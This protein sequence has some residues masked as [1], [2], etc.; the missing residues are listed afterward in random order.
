R[1]DISQDQ[2]QD[3]ER[4]LRLVRPKPLGLLSEQPALELAA[5]LQHL[6]VEPVVL[7]AVALSLL[8][9]L[10]RARLLALQ[11]FES[12]HQR[13]QLDHDVCRRRPRSRSQERTDQRRAFSTPRRSSA[14]VAASIV[15]DGGTTN[16]A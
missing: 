8:A 5:A 3:I 14:S 2:A 4:Q 13:L 1:A 10:L 12:L 11:R 7:V 9:R 15:R 16:R 6:E